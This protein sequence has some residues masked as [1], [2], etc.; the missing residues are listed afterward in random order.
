MEKGANEKRSPPR[1]EIQLGFYITDPPLDVRRNTCNF[2]M[3]SDIFRMP[4]GDQETSKGKKCGVFCFR[5]FSW[6]RRLFGHDE[7]VFERTEFPS[8]KFE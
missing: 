3:I 1:E 8:L 4:L 6:H 7:N 2:V 5:Y